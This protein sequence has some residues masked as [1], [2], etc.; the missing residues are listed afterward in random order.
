MPSDSQSKVKS[1]RKLRNNVVGGGSASKETAVTA[2]SD[3]LFALLLRN[4][5][6]LPLGIRLSADFLRGHPV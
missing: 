3:K 6:H 1:V 2:T 4:H 5:P